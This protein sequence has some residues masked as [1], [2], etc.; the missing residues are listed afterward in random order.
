MKTFFGVLISII[1]IPLLVLLVLYY[2]LSNSII[3]QNHI[4][5]TLA[6]SNAYETISS[7]ILPKTLLSIANENLSQEHQDAI[8]NISQ[9]VQSVI[10]PDWLKENFTKSY[11]YIVAYLKDDIDISKME[12]DL[13]AL[14]NIFTPQEIAMSFISSTQLREQ[15]E[16]LPICSVDQ[17]DN[18][19]PADLTFEQ[20]QQMLVTSV[21]QNQE[22]ASSSMTI[23]EKIN[24]YELLNSKGSLLDNLKNIYSLSSTIAL[25]I[26]G[27]EVLLILVLVIM[28]LSKP[29]IL[30]RYLGY[31]FIIS[32]I[33]LLVISMIPISSTSLL[34]S[35]IPSNIIPV[36]YAG[37]IM[38]I[39][40]NIIKS[41]FSNILI[42]SVIMVVVSIV[43][44]I[45][46]KK[47]KPIIDIQKDKSLNI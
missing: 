15:F 4:P 12:L 33:I 41:L 27:L 10:T 28:F 37:D 23:P 17:K 8:K 39:V 1:F 43:F 25:I 3:N 16:S 18:C 30:F 19:R 36:L 20:Y 7:D 34:S 22:I 38:G 24:L 11:A 26:V 42:I 9:K 2:S 47:T 29:N 13:S 44:F 6:R 35:I 45:I 5:Q 46:S 14:S 40:F 21:V 32:A 31:N